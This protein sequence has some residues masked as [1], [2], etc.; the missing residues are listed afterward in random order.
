VPLHEL[1]AAFQKE[2]SYGLTPLFSKSQNVAFGV[3]M[4]KDSINILIIE[5]DPSLL[6]MLEE[7]INFLG[8][9]SCRPAGPDKPIDQLEAL[10]PDLTILGPS[11][12]RETSLRCINKLKIIDPMMP[13]LTTSDDGRLP[14]G[15]AASP[16]FEGIHYLSRNLHPD[17]IS[18]A[19][20]NAIKHRSECELQPEFEFPFI[21][22]QSQEIENIKQKIQK[23]CN[24]DITILI[25]GETGTGKELIARSIHYH[26]QRRKGPLVKINCGALPDELLESEVFGFQRGAFTGA[27]KDKPGRLEMADGGTLFVDE[28]GE[29][30]LSLQV[31]F[32]QV[33]ED[34]AF[35]RLGGTRD[36]IID[37]RVIAATNAD[38]WKDVRRGT[39]RKDI[40]YRLNVVHIKAPSLRG[41]NENIRLLTH[42]FLNKYCYEFKRKFLEMP[43]KIAKFFMAYEWPGNVRELENVIRRAI[44][45]RDWHFILKEL[46]LEKVHHD[47]ESLSFP[48]ADSS[49]L[50]WQD[51]KVR[52]FFRDG[53]FSLK[54]L[55]NAY[56]SEAERQAILKALKETQWNRKKAAQLLHVSYKT[57]LNRILDFDL[58][59]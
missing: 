46:D 6:A 53:D 58:K 52:G 22:G 9:K 45:L 37:A 11:L 8:F 26:S 17:E 41:R 15:S 39:F 59:P 4:M 56:V 57:L 48:D 13:I 3:T 34:K 21:V 42:Y 5:T 35:S 51:D 38:L 23:V 32:L 29:L 44:A 27:H 18:E 33:L 55:R 50:D 24:K 36:K 43:N 31:K 10:G 1:F 25:T 12:D 16:P 19:I 30:S 2:T 28:I 49:L 14:S 20:E 7:K 47:A 54:K 40:F